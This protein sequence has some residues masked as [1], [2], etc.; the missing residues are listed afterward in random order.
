MVRCS[1]FNIYFWVICILFGVNWPI[2]HI[3]YWNGS[4]N[5][6]S[7]GSRWIP[8]PCSML[9]DKALL[10]LLPLWSWTQLALKALLY[11]I[12]CSTLWLSSRDFEVSCSVDC[13]ALDDCCSAVWYFT[14]KLDSLVCDWKYVK[15]RQ[16]ASK[17]TGGLS[18]NNFLKYG[19]K[20]LE[21][22]ICEWFFDPCDLDKLTFLSQYRT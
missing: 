19:D 22:V 8:R 1:L 11:E 16:A 15:A 10:L 20:S 5:P 21:F 13:L 3:F 9:L 17:V 12:S 6:W 18:V 14:N 2:V 4:I 7:Y